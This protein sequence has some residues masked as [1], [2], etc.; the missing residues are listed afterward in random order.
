MSAGFDAVHWLVLVQNELLLFSATFFALGALDEVAVDL[1]WLW[2]KLTGRI[3][4]HRIDREALPRTLAGRAAVLIPAWREEKVIAI[5][6]AHLLDAWPQA[7]LTLFVGCYRNDDATMAAVAGA[8]RS[9]PRIRLVVHEADGP[10]TKADCLN[11]LY[12]AVSQEEERHDFRFRLVMLQDAEDMV[13]PAALALADAAIDHADFVQFPVLPQPQPK[14]RWIGGHYCEEF[15][16]AHGKAMPV[17]GLIGAG[18][19]AAGVG[20]VF[21]RDMLARIGSLDPEGRPFHPDS[22]TEDY[23]LALR[24]SAMGGRSRFLR[25]RDRS[26]QLIA[27]RACFP[28]DLSAAVRQ[29][30]RWING[31]GLHGWDRVGWSARPVE[32]WMRLRDRRGLF[33]ALLLTM[34]YA[35]LIVGALDLLLGFLGLLPDFALPPGVWWLIALNFAHLCLRATT[36]FVFTTREYGWAEG[37]RAVARLPVSNIIAI[38]AARRALAAYLGVLR[39]SKVH[40]DKTDHPVHAVSLQAREAAG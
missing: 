11:R 23:E 35:L 2:G 17:R 40:W 37:F 31:I 19:P 14:S 22:L 6:I 4:T 26:G 24:I 29:K 15:A 32:I 1:L 16:E 7:E 9:D 33:S 8:V 5:T 10:T 18:L 34:A 21:A 36:R 38:I 25:A 13:D 28:A 12:R 3:R 30:S 20:C 39:G 27:T